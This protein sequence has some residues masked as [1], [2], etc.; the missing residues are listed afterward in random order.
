MA[1]RNEDQ[2]GGKVEGPMGCRVIGVYIKRWSPQR[3]KVGL[4]KGLFQASCRQ[5]V[6][7]FYNIFLKLTRMMP[8]HQLLPS[9]FSTVWVPALTS[10]ND[11]QSCGSA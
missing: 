9:H 1:E 5:N 8:L 7:L 6:M 3:M 4:D 10:F 2:I 11:E